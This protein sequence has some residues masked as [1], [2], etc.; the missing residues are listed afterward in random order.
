MDLSKLYKKQISMHD[1]FDQIDHKDA[2][3]IREEDYAR[4][5]RLKQLDEIIDLPYDKPDIFSSDDILN[6]TDRFNILFNERK[7][8]KCRLRL[9]PLTKDTQKLRTVGRT[10]HESV[11][12]FKEQDIDPKNYELHFL[13]FTDNPEWATIFVINN[14]GIFGEAV[15]GGHNQLTQGFHEKK[16]I[17]F[18][19]DFTSWKLSEENENILGHLQKIMDYLYVPDSTKQERLHDTLGADCVQNYITGYFETVSDASIPLQFI[20]YNRVLGKLYKDVQ[21]T[22]SQNNQNSITGQT[23]SPGV[24][25][26]KVRII[27]PEQISETNLNPD[28]I[29]VCDVTSPDYVPLMKQAAAIIT[30]RGGILSHAAIVSREMNKPCIVGTGNATKI[31]KNV[32]EIRV[33]A[34]NGTVKIL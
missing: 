28:E 33:N 26:G 7:D 4:Q 16:P 6:K 17:T 18:S 24:T 25:T 3:A 14:N 34:D 23:G 27:S 1:W 13:S 11:E 29:L 9:V 2:A 10:I 31:L 22:P 20:D 21:I 15:F 30:D 12:W 32:Q 19:F 5:A 8:K